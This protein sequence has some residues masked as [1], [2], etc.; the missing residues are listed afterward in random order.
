[1]VILSKLKTNY[2]S[3]SLLWEFPGGSVVQFSS[4]AQLCL[5]FFNPID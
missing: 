4:V 5:T 2:L 3:K 1:M